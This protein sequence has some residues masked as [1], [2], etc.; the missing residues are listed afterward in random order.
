MRQ[1]HDALR[2]RFL[3]NI[4]SFDLY[5]RYAGFF[6]TFEPY[7]KGLKLRMSMTF[8]WIMNC[9]TQ[10]P[11]F[12]GFCLQKAWTESN[13]IDAQDCQPAKL[14]EVNIIDNLQSMLARSDYLEGFH[15]DGVGVL[16]NISV[17]GWSKL[18]LQCTRTP[19]GPLSSIL[20]STIERESQMT[21]D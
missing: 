4:S 10:Q 2:I 15:Y 17:Y 7:Y 3:L 12:T 6:C 18:D 19:F 13:G 8:R 14:P 1:I 16:Q 11:I 21:N 9:S 20:V 5:C